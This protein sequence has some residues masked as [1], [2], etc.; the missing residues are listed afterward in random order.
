MAA[1]R[2]FR[3]LRLR[4]RS[5]F[6]SRRL[7]AE[8]D[9][10]LAYHVH[11][12]EQQ[13][14]ARGMAAADAKRAALAAMD[15]LTQ[16]TEEC[17]DARGTRFV[18]DLLHDL[19]YAVRQARKNAGF[20]LVVVTVLALAIGG[21]TAIFSVARAALA[22]LP[23]PDADRTVMVWSENPARNWHQFPAS[24]PDV[25]DWQASDVFGS[26]GG[27]VQAGFNLR[28]PDRTDRVEGLRSTPELFA[29][30]AVDPARGRAFTASDGDRVIVISDRLWRATF[31]ADPQVVGRSVVLDGTAHVIVGVLPPQFPRL[32]HE[33]LYAPLPNGPSTSERGTRNLGVVG[34]LRTGVSLTAA[35]ARMTDVSLALAKQYPNEDGGVTVVLQPLQ[36]AFVQDAALLLNLLIAAV[37]CALTIACANVASLL[38]A[39]G[40][41]RRRELAIRTALGGGRWRL[42]RQLITEHLL[43]A[44]VAG[45]VAI[46]PAWLGVRFITS[47]QLDELPNGSA[48]TLN[49]SALA[50]NFIVATVTGLLCGV[51]PAWL[52]WKSDISMALKASPAADAGRQQQR[53]RKLFVIGQVALTAILLVA[54]GLVL[55]SFLD[56]LAEAPGYNPAGVLTMRVALSE[57]QYSSPDR[58]TAFFERVVARAAALPGVVSASAVQELPT[59]DDLHGGG[60][61]FARRPDVRTEDVPLVLHTTVLPGYFKAMQIPLVRGRWFNEHDRKDASRV[62]VI[63]RWTANTYWPNGNPVGDRIRLGRKQPWLEIVGIVGDVEAPVLV[64]FLK[65]RVG[66]VYLPVAQDPYPAMSLVVRSAADEST[67]LSAMRAV[68]RDA[69][70]DQPVFKTQT[71]ADARGAGRRVVRLVMALLNGFAAMALLLA[72]VGLYGTV[73]YDVRQRTRE[74]GLRMSLGAESSD[75]LAAVLKQGARLLAVGVC[76]GVLGAMAAASLVSNALYG[77]RPRDPVTLAG[78]VTLLA[79]AGLL[80]TYLPARRATRI[81]PM[82]ALRAE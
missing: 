15:G 6:V 82:A 35:R 65:G 79:A 13:N 2:W 55:R 20:S 48:A 64:R 60:L 16:R 3:V 21:N 41:S 42:T 74:F 61:L 36:E 22:P 75:V 70:P 10:E 4:A 24:M 52:A 29:V 57:A 25:R 9:E 59:S 27:F 67:L 31:N 51:A 69:D 14:A 77:I 53:L 58:Q 19:R 56:M 73:A 30:L 45:V 18:E 8:L 47:Y 26:L 54:G 63:D 44:A 49:A 50:F 12:L 71:L 46:V 40:V 78:A 23:V 43:L 66:Q 68:V 81:E 1:D 32:S 7:N 11:Q 80:A 37:V 62:A 17:R 34:R 38:L 72:T 76:V 39:R 28:L 5:L 33:E